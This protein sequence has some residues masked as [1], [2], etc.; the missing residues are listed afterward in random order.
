MS[1]LTAEL[2]QTSGLLY[3]LEKLVEMAS[4]AISE[5]FAGNR[6]SGTFADAQ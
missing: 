6:I 3:G 4:P 1:S 5:G 2:R